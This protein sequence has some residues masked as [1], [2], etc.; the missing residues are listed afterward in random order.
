MVYIQ[1]LTLSHIHIQVMLF[2][3]PFT[4][5]TIQYLLKLKL[6]AESFENGDSAL[7]GAEKLL[8]RDVVVVTFNYRVGLLGNCDSN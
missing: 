7:Y 4:I 2:Y 5:L 6:L 8:D 1:G 3:N